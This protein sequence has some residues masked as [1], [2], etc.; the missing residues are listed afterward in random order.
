MAYLWAV[1]VAVACPWAVAV[2]SLLAVAA[3]WSATRAGR[4]AY[5]WAAFPSLWVR[6][7]ASPSAMGS[8]CRSAWEAVWP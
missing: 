1:V 4:A 8:V 6:R 5:C 2:K 7:S 3:A